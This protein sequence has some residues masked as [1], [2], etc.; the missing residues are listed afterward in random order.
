[1]YAASVDSAAEL[2]VGRAIVCNFQFLSTNFQFLSLFSAHRLARVGER[3]AVEERL[4]DFAV[5]GEQ[6][7]IYS[8]L[9][10]L[11]VCSPLC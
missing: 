4:T 2:I 9:G 7:E 3:R 11:S 5:D 1:M 6:L 10:D 8:I